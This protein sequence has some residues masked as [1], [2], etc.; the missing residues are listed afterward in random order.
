MDTPLDIEHHGPSF[1]ST[2]CPDTCRGELRESCSG[3]DYYDEE[4][5]EI[6]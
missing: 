2:Q 6:Q 3:C 4:G 5:E 1:E